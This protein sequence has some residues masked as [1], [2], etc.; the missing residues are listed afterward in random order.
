[1]RLGVTV[2]ETDAVV[3][4]SDTGVGIAPENLTQVFERFFRVNNAGWE[5]GAHAGLG[6]AITKS[7]LDLHRSRLTVSSELG[8]GTVFRFTLPLA[9]R[10]VAPAHAVA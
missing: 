3:Q 7:I 5:K 2:E 1:V 4:V 8:A 9:Q 6:L 10:D